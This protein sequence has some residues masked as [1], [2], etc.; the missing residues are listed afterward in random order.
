MKKVVLLLSLL[1]TFVFSQVTFNSS[2]IAAIGDTFVLSTSSAVFDTTGFSKTGTDFTWNYSF[3][4]ISKQ[5]VQRFLNP[6]ETGYKGSYCLLKGYLLNCDT[7]WSEIT[8]FAAKSNDPM[9]MGGMNLSDLTLHQKKTS[10]TL[11]ST[12]LGVNVSGFPFAVG[13]DEPDTMYRFPIAYQNQDSSKSYFRVDLSALGI[14]MEIRS[15]Q[16][17][18]NKVQGWGMLITPY[19]TFENTL[20]MRTYTER[21]DTMITDT[22]TF[23][24]DTVRSFEY[25]WMDPEY[26]FP[27]L[28]ASGSVVLGNE[29]VTNVSFIDS[30]RC[31]EPTASFSKLPLNV[32]FDNAGSEA[33]VTFFNYSQQAQNYEWDFGDGNNATEKNPVY[34]F[35]S[36]GLFDVQLIA[37]NTVC[38]PD[39]GDTLVKIIQVQDTTQIRAIFTV[40]PDTVGC[41]GESFVFDN[42]S[43]ETSGRNW[44]FGDGNTSTQKNPSHVYDSAGLFAVKLKVTGPKGADSTYQS[45]LVGEAEEI[46]INE[47]ILPGDSILLP[48]GSYASDTG[49][50][51]FSF[52]SW[53]GCDSIVNIEVAEGAQQYIERATGSVI[54]IYPNPFNNHLFFE[55]IDG[56]SVIRVRDLTGRELMLVQNSRKNTGIDFSGY[57]P[58]IYII[59][60]IG[61]NE[62]FSSLIIKN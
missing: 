20:K 44:Y 26:G 39:K 2:D 58:G 7:K 28:T 45:I 21:I 52:T 55:N 18:W 5:G 15:H 43:V 59:E 16:Y 14:N 9:E 10:E 1:P 17:R 29:V 8:N 32:Y 11:V 48:D 42:Y 53:L 57:K 37:V 47:T 61:K 35:T 56:I 4:D 31:F 33:E 49:V 34:I 19:D 23:A 38:E 3:L 25:K 6:N 22:G 51:S 30:L 50:Y 13:M 27:V 24:M 46:T 60:F 62:H 40:S 54:R 12:V 41:A 36:P